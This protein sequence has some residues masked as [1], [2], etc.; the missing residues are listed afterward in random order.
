MKRISAAL[1]IV[2]LVSCAAPISPEQKASRVKALEAELAFPASPASPNDGIG[3]MIA[4]DCSPS[5]NDS[6]RDASGN[7]AG[8]IEIAKRCLSSLVSKA[9]AFAKE[10][11]PRSSSTSQISSRA[12]SSSL[13]T[14]RITQGTNLTSSPRPSYPATGQQR[15]T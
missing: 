11:R 13:R 6:V 15:S 14:A 12:I 4:I 10:Q 8:K 7:P 3:L 5:M 1:V 9:E 2:L